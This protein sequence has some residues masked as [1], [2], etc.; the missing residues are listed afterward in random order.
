MKLKTCLSS[1]VLLMLGVTVSPFA[2]AED[3]YFK[4]ETGAVVVPVGPLDTEFL[5]NTIDVD[6]PRT[7]IVHYSAECQVERGHVEYDIVIHQGNLAITAR[8]AAPTH[9]DTSALC[10][11]D[12]DTLE[13]NMRASSVGSVVACTVASAAKYTVK[14]RGHVKGPGAIGP[15]LVDDQSLVIEERNFSLGVPPCVNALPGFPQQ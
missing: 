8:Q 10:S 13:S 1:A 5:A 7:L 4:Q 9:D 14:V 3:V 2:N 12:G 15:G 6:G 11:N